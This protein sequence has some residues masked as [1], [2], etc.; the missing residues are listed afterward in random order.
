MIVHLTSPTEAYGIYPG[1]QSGNPGSKFYDNMVDDWA[2]GKYYSL[3]MMN[4]AEATDKRIIGR[5]LFT[6]S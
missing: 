4:E 3:W 6:N 5:L 2:A 1:G